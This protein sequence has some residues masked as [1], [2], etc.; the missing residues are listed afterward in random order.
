MPDPMLA[1]DKIISEAQR[2]GKFEDLPG[3]GKPLETDTS[4][5]AAIKGVLKEANL[6][7]APEWITLAIEIDHLARFRT[8]ENADDHGYALPGVYLAWAIVILLLYPICARYDA[9]KRGHP[10]GWT[11][12]L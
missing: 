5:D 10:R 8:M 2:E 9:Y 6:S 1:L 3:K 11:R 12:Y 7:V 4:P